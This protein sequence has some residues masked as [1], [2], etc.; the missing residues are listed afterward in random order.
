MIVPITG[1][2]PIFRRENR[3]I[4]ILVAAQVDVDLL[5]AGH[6]HLGYAADVRHHHAAVRRSMLAIQAGT[7]I[8]TRVREHPNGY[9]VL[10]L[11]LPRLD[12]E[13]RSWDGAGF[14]AV[15]TRRF[16]KTGDAWR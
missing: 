11:D 10:R 1:G 14:D 16:E 6:L 12:L 4:S 9:N 2:E 8:S 3:E 13:V 15:E 5:L 7:A